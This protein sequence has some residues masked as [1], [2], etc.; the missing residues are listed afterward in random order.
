MKKGI[1]QLKAAQTLFQKM[2]DYHLDFDHVIQQSKKH[3]FSNI[4][5]LIVA[6]IMIL[7]LVTMIVYF[8][9]SYNFVS[10]SNH[11]VLLILSVAMMMIA[12][13]VAC[14]II[15]FIRR[16]ASD[17]FL[18]KLAHQCQQ[19]HDDP[20]QQIELANHAFEQRINKLK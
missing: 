20:Q 16:I 8:G 18:I 10:S 9:L 14:Y 2:I 6:V 19:Y 17:Q 5:N 11:P 3:R 15:I 12:I 13:I 7:A 1:E 4:I